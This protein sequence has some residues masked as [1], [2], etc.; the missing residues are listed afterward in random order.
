MDEKPME[1]SELF[2]KESVEHIQSPEQLNEYMR[3]TNPTIWVVLISVIIL[4]AGMLIWSRFATIN[5]FAYGTAIVTDGDMMVVFKD[6]QIAANVK[7][8]MTVTAGEKS[9]SIDY[10]GRLDDGTIVAVA[11]TDLAD[12]TYEVSV[13]FRRT[14]V[15]HLLFN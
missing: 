15:L 14:Q 3:V 11:D 13:E 8:G 12:G 9:T 1:N 4:L 6:Q 10:V 5:S 7:E 2:R